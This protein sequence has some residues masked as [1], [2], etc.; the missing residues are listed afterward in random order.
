MGVRVVFLFGAGASSGSGSVTPCPPP[1]GTD[2]YRELAGFSRLWATL[3]SALEPLFRRNFEQGM[4]RVWADA[5]ADGRL[6]NR[7]AML[8]REMG[9]YFAGFSAGSGNLYERLV[10]GIVKIGRFENVAF[11]TLNYECLLE[12][13]LRRAGKRVDYE[14]TS[15]S[16]G[17]AAVCWKLHGSCNFMVEGHDYQFSFI[18]ASMLTGLPFRVVE[19]AD[20]PAICD[21][22]SREQSLLFPIMA[23]YAP[24]KDVPFAPERVSR[25]QSSWAEAVN[26]AETVVVAGVRPNPGDSHIWGPLAATAARVLA[27]GAPLP[28]QQWAA[29]FRRGRRF[30]LLGSTFEDSL[31]GMIAAV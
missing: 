2:L 7:A 26:H 20:V 11:S 19:C 9:R 29:R 25:M 18:P 12:D 1:L 24:G 17:D 23:I 22:N 4:S 31:P 27:V 3:P 30:E 8:L 16:D 13:G 5:V 15:G 21:L 28:L 6:H 14:A 10:E